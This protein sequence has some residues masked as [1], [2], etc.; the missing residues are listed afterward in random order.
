MNEVEFEY[1]NDSCEVFEGFYESNLFDSD[2]LS[3]MSEFKPEPP[4]GYTWDIRDFKGYMNAIGKKAWDFILE[5]I[6][7]SE[8]MIL[9][10]KFKE[11]ISPR[12]Y[13]FS[14]DKLSVDVKVNMDE[15]SSY[16]FKVFRKEFNKYLRE[17]YSSRSGFISFIPNNVEDLESYEDLDRKYNVMF[18]FYI[19]NE[20][21]MECYEYDLHEIVFEIMDEYM[22]LEKDGKYY[23]YWIDSDEK[24]HL[25]EIK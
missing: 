9:E 10:S 16:C 22:C 24:V 23:D 4:E 15:L 2:S 13:N 5:N 8:Y 1:V 11:V 20:I 6:N 19:L 3:Y 12:F 25:E 21:D 7:G 18:E 14:T 17:N